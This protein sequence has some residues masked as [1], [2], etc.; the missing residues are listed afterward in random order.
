MPVS[1]VSKGIVG[2]HL[3]LPPGIAALQ[4][5]ASE[6]SC[7]TKETLIMT[8]DNWLHITKAKKMTLYTRI[9]NHAGQSLTLGLSH[10]V[11]TH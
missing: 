10:L 7:K 6:L 3:S 4:L 8:S 1:C 9:N 2:L 11:Q 5:A